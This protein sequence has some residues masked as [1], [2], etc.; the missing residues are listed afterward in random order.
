MLDLLPLLVGDFFLVL[1]YLAHQFLRPLQ[2]F[3]LRLQSLVH[4]V[5]LFLLL[6]RDLFNY[7]VDGRKTNRIDLAL[8]HLGTRENIVVV[9]LNPVFD[10][11]VRDKSQR[12]KVPD[13]VYGDLLFPKEFE[14]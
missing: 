13:E 3:L 14:R 12:V 4:G 2:I 7:L 8:A 10:H 11:I 6:P 9:S 1:L 5:N